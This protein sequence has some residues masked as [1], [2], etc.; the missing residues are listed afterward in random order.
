MVHDDENSCANTRNRLIEAARQAFMEEGYRASMDAI[1]A[2]A[3][4][5]KQT[6]YNHFACKQELFSESAR[7]FT[8]AITITLDNG[9]GDLHGSLV[10]FGTTFRDRALGAEGLAMF[11]SLAAEAMRLPELTSDVLCKGHDP[12]EARLADFL[13]RFMV[14]GRL[15]Q[16]DPAFA[17]QMLMGM[18]MG[19]DHVRRL[20][21]VP[22]PEENEDA[23]VD[24]IINCFLSAFA[25]LDQTRISK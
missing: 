6:L 13:A 20:C 14:N 12:T 9:T 1:A 19:P 18:L 7:L 15:R 21:A 10:R 16:D 2:R 25:P 3:G 8:E 23:R 24:K 17:A 22:M 11:R 5:A 4:V